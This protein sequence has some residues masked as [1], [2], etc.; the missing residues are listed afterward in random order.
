MEIPL[1]SDPHVL[2]M[3]YTIECSLERFLISTACIFLLDEKGKV[4]GSIRMRMRGH[5]EGIF[6]PMLSRYRIFRE[7]RLPVEINRAESE[8]TKRLIFFRRY[9]NSLE[10]SLEVIPRLIFHQIS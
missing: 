6:H 4:R 8:P 7:F 9:L 2:M 5:F 3:E 10:T 1:Q